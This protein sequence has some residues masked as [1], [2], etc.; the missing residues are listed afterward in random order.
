[1]NILVIAPHPDDEAIGCGGTICKHTARGDRVT[2]AFLTSGELGLKRLPREKAWNIREA[3]ARS[4]AKI[5]RIT[6]AEFLR[7]PDWTAGTYVKEGARLLTPILKREKP[8]I[9][10]APHPCEW[11][12][13]HQA[14]L[15]MLRAALRKSDFA[16]A[17]LRGYEVWTP[18]VE[19]DHVENISE[20]MPRKLRA[21]RAHRSQ[22]EEFD[23]ERAV[24]GLNQFRGE[25][26]GKCRYAEV[27]QTLSLKHA[28]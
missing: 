25:L 17:E 5:L 15:P 11:H 18:M 7:L 19:H 23:Y 10:Y 4:A 28:R 27:F 3:E 2:V 26:A 9:I 22:L 20:V 14:A 1:M 24:R 16:P 21:L 13:D 8:G 6:H 12:P